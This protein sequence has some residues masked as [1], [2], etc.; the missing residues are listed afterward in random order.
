MSRG[1]TEGAPSALRVSDAEARRH[2]RPDLPSSRRW[3]RARR[4]ERVSRADIAGSVRRSSRP[5]A[6]VV[7]PS[8]VTSRRFQVNA[9]ASTAVPAAAI[10]PVMDR[11]NVAPAVKRVDD[12][13][14]KP[15]EKK[16][17]VPRAGRARCALARATET[18]PHREPFGPLPTVGPLPRRPPTSR[19]PRPDSPR[20]DPTHAAIDRRR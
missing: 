10:Q 16:R 15:A 7:N 13:Q 2:R 9:M 11:E 17:C 1:N 6:R 5:R 8:E 14:A 18:P 4:I 3:I 12:K 19:S 20:P